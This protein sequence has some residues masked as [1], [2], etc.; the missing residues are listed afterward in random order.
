M[1]HTGNASIIYLV[2]QSSFLQT[3]WHNILSTPL[4]D[5]AVA[6]EAGILRTPLLDTFEKWNN[7]FITGKKDIDTD[8]DTYVAEMNNAGIEKY[9]TLYNEH[10]R[11]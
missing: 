9:L 7:D 6:E 10:V 4:F 11:K 3:G 2:A 5:D 8:W 1:P